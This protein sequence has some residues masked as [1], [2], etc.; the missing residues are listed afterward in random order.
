MIETVASYAVESLAVE[1]DHG[2][3]RVAQDDGS[4]VQVIRKTLE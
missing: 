1:W 3:G 2:M 4:I